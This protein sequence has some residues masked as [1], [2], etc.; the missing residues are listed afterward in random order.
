V[1][2]TRTTETA[3]R[4]RD[5][6]ME[7]IAVKGVQE[8]SLREIAE[9]AGITKPA[10]YY[11]FGSREELLRDLVRPLVEDVQATLDALEADGAGDPRAVLGGYFDVAYRHR[12]ITGMV[13]RDPRFLVHVD[14]ASAVGQWRRRLTALLVGPE[15]TLAEQARVALA[16][17]GL[18]D[19]AAL[20]VDAPAEELRTAVLDAACA[21]LGR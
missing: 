14:L 1:P 4:I 7:V 16:I 3:D 8:A 2:R 5:A 21:A 17:G 19:C 6:A 20:F 18:G 15:P 11:H 13:I 9:R 10:L 12:A